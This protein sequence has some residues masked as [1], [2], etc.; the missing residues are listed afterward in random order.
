M[1][2]FTHSGNPAAQRWEMNSNSQISPT[3]RLRV[4]DEGRR[5]APRVGGV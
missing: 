4:R 5:K 1:L 3:E 2:A